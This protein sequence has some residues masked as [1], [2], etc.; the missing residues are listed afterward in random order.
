MCYPYELVL[1]LKRLKI[2]IIIV[3]FFTVIFIDADDEVKFL[4]QKLEIQCSWK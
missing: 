2:C 3:L 4:I 1:C